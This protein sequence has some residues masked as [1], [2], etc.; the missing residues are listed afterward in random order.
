MTFL[1]ITQLL[2]R[3]KYIFKIKFHLFYF[4][5]GLTTSWNIFICSHLNLL[6]HPSLSLAHFISPT[7]FLSHSLSCSFLSFP[8]PF[9]LSC[10]GYLSYFL[11]VSVTYSYSFYFSHSLSFSFFLFLVLSVSPT[12]FLLC[13]HV[14]VCKS[15]IFVDWH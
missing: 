5:K 4:K 15:V 9:C 13:T 11:S 7:F 14:S 8:L 12:F 3:W 10:F 6:C 1:F 2:M